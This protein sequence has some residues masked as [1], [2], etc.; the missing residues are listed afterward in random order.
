MSQPC[1]SMLIKCRYGAIDYECAKLFNSVL[2]D[3]G[4]CC[5]FNGVHKR[6]IMKEEYKL[7]SFLFLL[8]LLIQQKSFFVLIYS[9]H[10][11][12]F[13]PSDAASGHAVLWTPE[14]GFEI[15]NR[16]D[17][18]TYPKPALGKLIIFENKLKIYIKRNILCFQQGLAII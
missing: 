15:K 9:S 2:T 8:N 12:E 5:I 3:E 6:F 14:L 11:H 10:S 7:F 4:L 17:K 18:F 1:E 16:K 13:D